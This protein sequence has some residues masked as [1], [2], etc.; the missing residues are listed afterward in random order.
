MGKFDSLFFKNHFQMA[1]M[2]VIL[3]LEHLDS[4]V[5]LDL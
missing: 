2:A 4:L 3:T 5:L 1:N